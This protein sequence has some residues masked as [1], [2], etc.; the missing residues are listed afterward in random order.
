MG[1]E[2][3]PDAT[4]CEVQHLISESQVHQLRRCMQSEACF[5]MYHP[6]SYDMSAFFGY[7]LLYYNTRRRRGITTKLQPPGTLVYVFPDVQMVQVEYYDPQK[8]EKYNK[9]SV[10]G[11]VSYHQT[12]VCLVL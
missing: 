1:E 5:A 9:E 6:F 3:Q 8:N 12:C 2:T 10:R 11:C 4:V 7:D